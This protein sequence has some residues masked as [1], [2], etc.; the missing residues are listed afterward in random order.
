MK[1]K[2]ASQVD[3]DDFPAA[4]TYLS[5]IFEKADAIKLVKK[6]KKS[7]IEEFPAKDILRASRLSLDSSSDS[8]TAEK[9]KVEQGKQLSPILLVR[10]ERNGTLI[11]A[12]GYH[13]LCV[14]CLFTE[15]A[16]VPA[17]II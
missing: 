14:T 4:E 17:K 16:K 12:D 15:D 13:R 2:W 11:I 7:P 9:R 10:D 5:L 6:L 3:K 1:I 8:L